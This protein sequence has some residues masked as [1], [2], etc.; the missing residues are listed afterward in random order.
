M[1]APLQRFVGRFLGLSLVM[2][3]T[4][5]SSRVIGSDLRLT[6]QDGR[7]C[8]A[9]RSAAKCVRSPLLDPTGTSP[10]VCSPRGHR[11][12]SNSLRRRLLTSNSE[13]NSSTAELGLAASFDSL[14]RELAHRFGVRL[15]SRE[16]RRP[17]LR[18]TRGRRR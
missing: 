4:L 11:R 7:F 17:F 14:A 1:K 5:S 16:T 9:R 18:F 6:T 13:Q 10:L 8:A 3:L 2:L 12:F 15:S